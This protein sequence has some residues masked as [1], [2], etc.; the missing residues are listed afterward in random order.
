MLL[1]WYCRPQGEGMP[2]G[3]QEAGCAQASTQEGRKASDE[4]KREP[5]IE[6]RTTTE[7]RLNSP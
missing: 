1:M 2:T 6:P 5:T 4:D 7:I 3:A